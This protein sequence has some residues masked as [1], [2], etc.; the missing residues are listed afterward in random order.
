[1]TPEGDVVSDNPCFVDIHCHMLPGLDDGP[2]N[3]G[4]SLAMAEIAVADGIQAV[5]VTPHQLGTYGRNRGATI[6]A[7]AVRFQSELQQRGISLRVLPGADVRIEPDLVSKL[8]AGEVLTL[9][10]RRRHV[11]LELPHE[12]YVPLQGL[13]RKL[14]AAGI[15]GIL[16]HPERNQGLLREPQLVADLVDAGC[17]MQ[18]TAGSLVGSF[19]AQIRDFSAWLIEEGLVHFVATD[20]HGTTSR[21]P[22]ISPA[23]ERIADLAGDRYAQ[24][25]CCVNP[26]AIAAGRDIAGGRRQRSSLK[27]CGWF[28]RRRAS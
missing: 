10:D 8:E 19:G 7:F 27:P 23:F 5:V 1:M 13:L 9:A 17:L 3:L 22:R 28:H 4:V 18:V 20:A 26:S 14:D 16:S 11:L 25:L 24:E 21:R 15:V 2:V 6:R 12:L